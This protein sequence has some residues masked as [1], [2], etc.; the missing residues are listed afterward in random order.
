MLG[1]QEIFNQSGAAVSSESQPL[2]WRVS[3]I[4]AGYSCGLVLF[5][6]VARDIYEWVVQGVG[7]ELLEFA[8]WGI[9]AVLLATTLRLISILTRLAVVAVFLLF[10]LAALYAGSFEI[11][12]ERTHLIK[13]GTL[14]V[15]LCRDNSTRAA[16]PLAVMGLGGVLWVGGIDEIVQSF[17]PGRVGDIR[18]VG[19]NL[20]GGL[21]GVSLWGILRWGSGSRV[22]CCK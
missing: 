1:H 7:R 6:L 5:S 18:D 15:L 2:S 19:F 4:T 10:L 3:P 8:L 11:L 14:A 22:S 17:T 20:V 9:F 16:I 21:F 12:E 13:Y